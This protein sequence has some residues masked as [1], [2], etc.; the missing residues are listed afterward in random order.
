[1]KI[2]IYED[3]GPTT[4]KVT[5][6]FVTQA[7]TV[8]GPLLRVGDEN[9]GCLACS[10]NQPTARSG[11]VLVLHADKDQSDASARRSGVDELCLS[12]G[13]SDKERATKQK[14]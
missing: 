6:C 14:C 9:I 5:S 13:F 11:L 1:M 3:R 12:T 8:E 4:V 10:T 2:H 7:L